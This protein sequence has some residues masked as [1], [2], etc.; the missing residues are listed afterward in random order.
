MGLITFLVGLAFV[1]V[2]FP[3]RGGKADI[4]S[5]GFGIVIMAGAY[6]LGVRPGI[7]LR[8]DGIQVRNPLR[9]IFLPWTDLAEVKAVDVVVITDQAGR[10][11]RC[12]AISGSLRTL[13]RVEAAV[14][15]INTKRDLALTLQSS[16]GVP[17]YGITVPVWIG[18]AGF[19]IGAALTVLG[20]MGV[21][22]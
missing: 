1:V 20:L 12:Y 3:V 22:G 9:T 7:G 5:I 21:V 13:H 8:P 2:G 19:V 10:S 16:A 6:I 18:V 11:S 15:E 4:A 14:Q 17:F